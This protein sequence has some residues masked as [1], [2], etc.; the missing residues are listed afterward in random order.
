MARPRHSASL[1]GWKPIMADKKVVASVAGVAVVGILSYLGY[2]VYKEISKINF[3]D[4]D[5][6]ETDGVPAGYAESIKDPNNAKR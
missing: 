3:D 1:I 5:W 4:I 6:L 2:R